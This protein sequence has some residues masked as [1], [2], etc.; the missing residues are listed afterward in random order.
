MQPP[1]GMAIHLH[2]CEVNQTELS[3]S[4]YPA[5][6]DLV[7]KTDLTLLESV[8]FESHHILRSIFPPVL[9]RHPGLR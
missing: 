8:I 4:D 6:Q 9:L 5:Y 1:P 2:P 3:A 7:S